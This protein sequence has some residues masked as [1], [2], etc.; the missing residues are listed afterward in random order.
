MA[1]YQ[2]AI[3]HITNP[4]PEMKTYAETSAK[5][6]ADMGGEY[7]VRGPA[8]EVKEGE[9]LK[10]KVVLVTT[11]PTMDQMKAFWASDEYN[12]IKH[13]RDGTGTYDV[14]IYGS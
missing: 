12:A 13:L 2:I 9:F 3:C 11:F 6:V 7:L 4:T 10:G 8:A 1:A 14:A 5:I